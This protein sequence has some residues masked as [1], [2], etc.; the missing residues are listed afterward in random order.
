[1]AQ[2][3]SGPYKGPMGPAHGTA[4]DS[5]TAVVYTNLALDPCTG[6]KY[7][8]TNGYLL[9]GPNN[10]GLAGSTQ[11]LAYPF[12]AKV[13]Q[14]VTKVSLAVT[15]WGVCT[16]TSNKFT[17]AIYSDTCTGVPGAQIGSSVVATAPAAPPAL[18]NAN[19][20]TAGVSVVAGTRYWVVATTST[21][22]TQ[23]GTTAVWWDATLGGNAANFND[24]NGWF[25]GAGVGGFQVQ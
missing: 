19:F 22:S 7:D 10:C 15:D 25:G 13:S 21:A 9:L 6:A 18:A 16:A 17:V 24:G 4:S 14:A 1:M 2:Q 8:I 23:T 3:M 11:W 5:V 20:G 12:I